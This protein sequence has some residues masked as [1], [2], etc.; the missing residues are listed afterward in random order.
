MFEF[1]IKQLKNILQYILFTNLR[2]YFWGAGTNTDCSF[3][4]LALV[5]YSCNFK[6][7]VLKFI[8]QNSNFGYHY[9]I[10][11]GH[12]P[13]NQLNAKVRCLR[14]TDWYHYTTNHYVRRCWPTYMSPYGVNRPQGV[15]I[16]YY[17]LQD[18]Y[19][20][21]FGFRCWMNYF[22]EEQNRRL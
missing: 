12:M 4:L 19:Q 7:M 14:V 17:A 3:K 20:I 2:E 11:L 21:S 22:Y 13:Q 18:L 10:A 9:R 15:R 8:I 16:R 5:R 6:S 1:D